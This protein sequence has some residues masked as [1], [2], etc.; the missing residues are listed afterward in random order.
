MSVAHGGC[1]TPQEL[2]GW[3]G[4]AAKELRIKSQGH[5]FPQLCE[6]AAHSGWYEEGITKEKGTVSQ[7]NRSEDLL[8]LL[9][10]PAKRQRE[11]GLLD[12]PPGTRTQL[13]GE[14]GTEMGGGSGSCLLLLKVSFSL[15]SVKKYL[16]MYMN[17]GFFRGKTLLQLHTLLVGRSNRTIPLRRGMVISYQVKHRHSCRTTSKPTLSIYPGENE[18]I[19]SLK[20][21]CKNVHSSFIHLC[22]MWK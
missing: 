13:F 12:S 18:N 20:D 4:L 5:V 2:L 22:K 10:A 8:Q 16:Q 15:Y 3:D 7:V 9:G 17:V 6:S 1:A 11:T 21:M 14:A 19:C